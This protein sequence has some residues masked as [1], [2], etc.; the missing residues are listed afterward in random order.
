MTKVGASGGVWRFRDTQ[1]GVLAGYS[2][3]V[4]AVFAS[5]RVLSRLGPVIRSHM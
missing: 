2:G 5:G 4:I 3:K 1:Y